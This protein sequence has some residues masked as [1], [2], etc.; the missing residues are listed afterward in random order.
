LSNWLKVSLRRSLAALDNDELRAASTPKAWVAAG[1]FI[2]L[3][4]GINAHPWG[5]AR[6]GLDPWKTLGAFGVTLCGALTVTWLRRRDGARFSRAQSLA[7][8]FGTA[9]TQFLAAT[10]FLLAR[11]PATYLFALFVVVTGFANGTQTRAGL[12]RPWML[13]GTGLAM[14]AAVAWTGASTRW[15]DATL[16]GAATL[17]VE[18]VAGEMSW[19]K[20]QAIEEGARM[21]AAVHAQI[22]G[23]QERDAERVGDALRDVTRKSHAIADTAQEALSLCELLLGSAP[24]GSRQGHVLQ[25]LLEQVRR[26]EELALEAT[27]KSQLGTGADREPV[28]LAPVA[29]L[30]RESIGYRFPQV[31]LELERG[32]GFDEAVVLMPGG[33]STLRRILENTL[34]NA[35]EGDGTV[36]GSRVVLSCAP[37]VVPGQ[38]V[39]EIRDDGP[40]FPE[41]VLA[42]PV[43]GLLTTKEGR[44]NGLGLY[45][46][47]C[48]VRAGGGS[49]ERS[50]G[51]NGGA[52]VRIVVPLEQAPRRVA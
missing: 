3:L 33:A 48:L 46:A 10:L 22:I 30:I 15:V 47:E 49:L 12:K 25:Q 28:A 17:M 36:A 16:V 32:E 1:A 42:S 7:L 9:G 40:G 2:A 11:S 18:L 43:E 41:H 26:L 44:Q 5:E 21:R 23:L 52:R 51:E 50:N 37:R 20:A 8:L 13:V 35:C 24:R 19:A 14:V 27:S 39:L 38:V 34:L 6:L 29:G 45:T 31:K 4:L